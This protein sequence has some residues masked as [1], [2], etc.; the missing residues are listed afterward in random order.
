MPT[1][2]FVVQYHALGQTFTGTTYET[3]PTQDAARSQLQAFLD[4]VPERRG[5][6]VDAPTAGGPVNDYEART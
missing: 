5:E 6:I 4:L 2:Q 1:F 3:A